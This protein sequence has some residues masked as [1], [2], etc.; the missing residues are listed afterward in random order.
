MRGG[1]MGEVSLTTN[2]K[3]RWDLDSLQGN[4]NIPAGP[5]IF[6]GQGRQWSMEFGPRSR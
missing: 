3:N 2:L 4:E 1:F 6:K 5:I